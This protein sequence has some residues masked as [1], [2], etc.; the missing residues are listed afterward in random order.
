MDKEEIEAIG[1][2]ILNVAF[3]LHTKFGSGLLEKAYRTIMSAE[4]RRR[5][6]K[7]EEEKVCG[8]E[9]NG[10]YYDNMFRMDMLVDECIVVELKSVVR[11]E[12]VFAKQ[13]LTYMR[14]A[15]L[16]LGYV[17]NFGMSS[18]KDGIVRVVNSL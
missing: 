5:G 15:D 11:M 2:D 12:L 13:C 9:F 1:K 4:L 3:E 16:K 8:I 14:F 10:I 7:V 17:I 18:L 6:H